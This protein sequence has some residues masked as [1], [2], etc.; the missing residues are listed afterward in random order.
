MAWRDRSL[1]HS[2]CSGERLLAEHAG[3]HA[4]HR[5]TMPGG[6]SP[7]IPDKVESVNADPRQQLM[8]ERNYPRQPAVHMA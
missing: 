3:R 7:A 2:S 6:G 8:A 1:D 5:S 4:G